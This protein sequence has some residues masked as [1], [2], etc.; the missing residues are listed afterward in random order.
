MTTNKFHTTEAYISGGIC[1]HMW[2]P[3]AMAGKPFRVSLRGP[4]G[5][6]DRFTELATFRD[7]LDLCLSEN[8]GDFQDAKFTADTRI[9][10]VRVAH[11]ETGRTI[12][13]RERE[14]VNISDLADLVA[15]DSFTGDFMGDDE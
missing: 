1:G 10:V 3:N 4:F 2:M 6:M 5:V 15:E 7:A 13:V 12:H 11:L 14:L 8:G 9:V